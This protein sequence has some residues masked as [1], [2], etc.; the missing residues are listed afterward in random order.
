MEP[1]ESTGLLTTH[2]NILRLLDILERRDGYIT[3]VDVDGFNYSV[4]FDLEA[5]KSFVGI[6]YVLSQREDSEYWKQIKYKLNM[7]P[8]EWITDGYVRTPRLYMEFIHCTNVTNKFPDL[9]GSLYIAAGM[10]YHPISKTQLEYELTRGTVNV[11]NLKGIARSHER[12]KD[13]VLRYLKNA[14]SHFEFLRDN[15]YETSEYIFK[16]ETK[17]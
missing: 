10:G 6:H 1:L 4:D 11:E 15:I 8:S 14:P 17:N 12:Y 5:F 16:G 7:I 2:E 3:K 13:Q 9:A